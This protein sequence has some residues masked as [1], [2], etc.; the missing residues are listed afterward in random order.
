MQKEQTWQKRRF[1]NDLD[2]TSGDPAAKAVRVH[3][4][5]EAEYGHHI[6]QAR[7]DPLSEL[8]A[9]ILSQNTSD[10]NSGRA[11]KALRA[12]FPSWED[13]RDA[14]VEAVAAAIRPGGLADIKAPRIQ[15]ILKVITQRQGALNLDFLADLPTA[16]ARHWLLSLEGVGPKTAACV[17][18]F[19]LGKP[20]LPVDTHVHRLA[21]RLGLVDEGATPEETERKLEA[22][23]PPADLY[24]FHLNLIAHGRRV[25]R[26]QR[27]LCQQC[28]LADLCERIGVK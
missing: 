10:V 19:S 25:C 17:L 5:L 9:T 12:A 15:R 26:S 4:L 23:L 21:R 22:L 6:W 7:A 11:Y 2:G 14:P 16:E 1:T 28:V 3:R 24:S 13:V 20:V 8:I 27:P 18:L